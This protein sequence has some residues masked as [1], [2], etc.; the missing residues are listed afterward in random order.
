MYTT[1]IYVGR[2][3][4]ISPYY[5]VQIGLKSNKSLIHR[6]RGVF[7]VNKTAGA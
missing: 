5:P 6:V 7:L 3:N 1:M 4:D 2:G